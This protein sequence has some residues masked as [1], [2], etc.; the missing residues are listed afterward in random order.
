MYLCHCVHNLTFRY[1]TVKQINGRHVSL[2][3]SY[4][5]ATVL[6]HPDQKKK[7][8]KKKKKRVIIITHSF[9]LIYSRDDNSFS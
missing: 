8:E 6:P 7:K 4:E 5:I 3:S 9:K 1:H 2:R